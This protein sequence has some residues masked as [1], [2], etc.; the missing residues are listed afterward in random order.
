MWSCVNGYWQSDLN[1]RFAHIY[2]DAELSF[3]EE[4]DAPGVDAV[5]ESIKAICGD[6]SRR[7]MHEELITRLDKAGQLFNVVIIKTP[8]TIPYTTTFFELDCAYWDASRQ[9]KLDAAVKAAE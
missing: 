3:I 6:E 9:A 4:A 2:N 8:L 5:R 1:H 7:V